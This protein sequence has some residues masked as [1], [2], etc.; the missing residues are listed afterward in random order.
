V[1]GGLSIVSTGRARN[2]V[3]EL[4]GSE[5]RGDVARGSSRA[6][7]VWLRRIQPAPTSAPLGGVGIRWISADLA[8][9]GNIDGRRGSRGG[10]SPGIEAEEP[11]PTYPIAGK[12]VSCREADR[13]RAIS[14]WRASTWNGRG[15]PKPS[16][17]PY[18]PARLTAC[19]SRPL[20][21]K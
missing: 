5:Y 9:Q 14:G 15:H 10:F 18:F 17:C 8:G 13:M 19:S 6:R 20:R 1:S 16:P 11:R 3:E 7:G 2:D 4:L 12:S 21:C